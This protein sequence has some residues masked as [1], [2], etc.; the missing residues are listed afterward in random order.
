L[1]AIISPLDLGHEPRALD[2][3]QRDR[4]DTLRRLDAR[5]VAFKATQRTLELARALDRLA[6]LQ[7][8]VL[9]REP[10]VVGR[11]HERPVEARRTH[12]EALVVDVL[13]G[14]QP[15]QV[16]GNTRAVLDVDAVRLVDEHA[17][18]PRLRRELD[19][20]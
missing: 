8:H 16:V 6:Q 1:V 20:D 10:D 2:A 5:R 3:R 12:L 19:V 4:H 15:R 14:E 7:L 13:D 17:H 9:P 11:L 18:L